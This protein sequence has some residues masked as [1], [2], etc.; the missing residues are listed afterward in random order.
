MIVCHRRLRD[1]VNFVLINLK[2][3]F[4]KKCNLCPKVLT[5]SFQGLH[6]QV[7]NVHF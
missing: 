2:S 1:S 3:A 7:K 4:R 5:F 6:L